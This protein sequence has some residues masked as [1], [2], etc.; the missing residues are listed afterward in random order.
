MCINRLES[1]NRERVINYWKAPP[2]HTS[3]QTLSPTRINKP[4]HFVVS[5]TQFSLISLFQRLT[6]PNVFGIWYKKRCNND[7]VSLFWPRPRLKKVPTPFGAEVKNIKS[8]YRRITNKNC[9]LFIPLLSVKKQ[10]Y[11][12]H[13]CCVSVKSV[14]VLQ[15]WFSLF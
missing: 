10:I 3:M 13:D 12:L 2:L 1:T 8:F 6:Q 7:S 9:F 11:R 5:F 15:C 4:I 14:I